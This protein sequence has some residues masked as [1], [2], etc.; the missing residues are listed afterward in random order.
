M[1]N[2]NGRRSLL[3]I[4]L[5]FI[6]LVAYGLGAGT[7][8]LTRQGSVNAPTP[9]AGAVPTAGS[10]ADANRTPV[11]GTSG[12][13]SGSSLT[14]SPQFNSFMSTYQAIQD[15]FY[16]RPADSQK[17]IYGATKGMIQALGDDYSS[18]QTPQEAQSE[19]STMGGNFQGVGITIGQRNNL[20]T[21][22]SPIPNTPAERAG[23]RAR[24]IILAVDGRDVTKLTI[25]EIANLVR[26][27]ANTKVRLTMVRQ[28]GQA[29][30][31][32]LTRAQIDVPEVTLKMLDGNIADVEVSIF[33]DKTT[34]ELDKAL[35]QAQ[36]QKA[37]GIILDLRNNGGGWVVAAEEMLGRFLPV[38]T[39]AF[40][41][42]HK[43]DHSDDRAQQT[44]ANAPPALDE[45][46]MR[47]IPMVVLI[48]GGTASASEITSGAL[49][50]YGRAKLI[51]E[52]S[53]GKGSEQHV[54][55]W[56]DGTS[57][58]I[59]FAHWLTP[60]KRDINPKPTPNTNGT[61]VALPTFT[62]TPAVKPS[63]PDAT[64]TA[65]ARPLYPVQ[66][67]R[68][69]TPDIVVIRNE[70]D[71]LNDKDPQMDRATE[72]LKTGK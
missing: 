2:N 44:L 37:V 68:G 55:Q 17:M 26:G 47:K 29:F 58:H 21:V 43:S 72:Y 70:K 12:T 10:A 50:D 53:F 40:Y 46:L 56:P 23:I 11:P 22:I 64:S 62:P 49:Q 60:H 20:P 16:Y 7:M 59:T 42:S 35:L 3:A 63:A 15:E 66:T 57:A 38:D 69:L 8:Y 31:V 54:H 48:N 28:G 65:E 5:V 25:E 18:F 9:S 4:L 30:D 24:D 39:I 51:G 45:T 13:D 33:G 6:A 32:E 52:Q 36:Q 41:E 14:G 27:P 34:A 67:D 71:Y 19:R 61:P 1:E